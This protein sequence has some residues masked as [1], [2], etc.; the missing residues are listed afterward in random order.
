MKWLLILACLIPIQLKTQELEVR[1]VSNKDL[2]CLALNIHHE[3]RGES[4][5]G[6]I[7][8][9]H[10]V[11]NR[12][13][14]ISFPKTVCGVIK[15]PGQFSW[16]HKEYIMP[17][18]VSYKIHELAYNILNGKY[19]DPTNGA[20]YFHNESVENFKRKKVAKIGSHTFYS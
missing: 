3:A 1:T 10:V 5:T 16:Y 7:A 6:M 11:L 20:L 15:Q 8:V 4:V 13:K 14:H 19:K 18:N 12:V 9:G 17:S 2:Q